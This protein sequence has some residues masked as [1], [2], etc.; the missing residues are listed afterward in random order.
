VRTLL[1]S[2]CCFTIAASGWLATMALALRR[3]GYQALAGLALFCVLQSVLTIGVMAYKRSGYGARAVLA[4]GAAVIVAAG[5]RA[6][7]VNVTRSHFEGYALIIGVALVLQGLLTLRSIY[8][9]PSR[10]LGRTAPIW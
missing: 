10:A 8:V 9:S 2:L 7:F 3:P 1:A 4:T 5:G 6:V